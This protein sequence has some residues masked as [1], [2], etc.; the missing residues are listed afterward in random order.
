ML[1]Y[2]NSR[3]RSCLLTK[4]VLEVLGIA[5]FYRVFKLANAVDFTSYQVTISEVLRRLETYTKVLVWAALPEILAGIHMG[6]IRAV[7][8]VVIGQLLVSIIAFGRMFSTYSRSFLLEEFWALTLVLFIFALGVSGL[9]GKLE[10]KVEYY[11]G[12]RN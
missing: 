9:I 6:L 2:R 3:T 4:L 12:S 5:S 11:A 1:P 8:E 7:K 10:Q